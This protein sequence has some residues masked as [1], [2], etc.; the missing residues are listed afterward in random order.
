MAIG[1]VTRRMLQMFEACI[2]ASSD[3]IL[4]AEPEIATHIVCQVG[5]ADLH[6]CPGDA[7]RADD[8]PHVALLVSE[9]V[10]DCR[11][12]CGFPGIGS[13]HAR[14]HRTASRL[15]A[16]NPR[17]QIALPQ[18]FL[19]SGGTSPA[20]ICAFSASVLRCFG[21][22]TMEASTIKRA[23]R[24]S[25]ASQRFNVSPDRVRIR[26]HIRHRIRQAKDLS[27][28]NCI[29]RLAASG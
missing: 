17:D 14:R 7:D 28:N 26:H 6:P 3:R 9:H 19:V 18:Q 12:H 27:P 25:T 22:A 5:E 29:I 24:A 1:G 21:A 20:L 10:L 11:A 2:R 15:L 23:N 13:S 16:V 8:Q 4:T